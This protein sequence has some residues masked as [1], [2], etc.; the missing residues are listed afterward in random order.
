MEM[1]AIKKEG[2]SAKKRDRSSTIGPGRPIKVVR[3]ASGHDCLEL[4]DSSDGAEIIKVESRS[5]RKSRPPT[6][7]EVIDLLDQ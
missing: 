6:K 5:A 2:T 1:K 4:D 7:I 3:T